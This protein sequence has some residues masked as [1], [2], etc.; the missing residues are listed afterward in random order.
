[1]EEDERFGR[2]AIRVL[3]RFFSL[4]QKFIINDTE[5]VPNGVRLRRGLLGLF[6]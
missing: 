4:L 6:I 2:E 3:L 1:M 5:K